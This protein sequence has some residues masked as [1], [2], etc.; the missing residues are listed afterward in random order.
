MA[1]PDSNRV[2]FACNPL[3]EVTAQFKF[4]PILRIEAEVPAQFQEAIRME[5]PQYRQ[6][7]PTSQLPANT[8]VPVRNLIQGMGAAAGSSHHLFEALDRKS[9]VMLS[10]ETL[11]FKTTDY[12]RW[13]TFRTQLEAL[14]V[15]LEQIYRPALYVRLGLRYVDIIRRSILGLQNVP[16]SDLLNP[17]VGGEL[18]AP[19]LGESIESSSSQLHCKLNGDNCFLTLRTG[20]V[21]AE[22]A[23]EKCFLIDCDFHTH[24]ATELNHVT[25]FLNGFNRTSGNLFRWAIRDRLRDALRPQPLE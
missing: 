14:R 22:P 15:T 24:N 19:E 10:R 2:I 8:P 23:K 13:E 16:W 11:T 5:Y 7:R 25:P 1:L 20:I 4:P 6:V 9:S 12:T 21:L 18:T 3:A 17:S